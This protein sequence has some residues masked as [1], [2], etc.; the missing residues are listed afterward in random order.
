M[1]RTV[2]LTATKSSS[3]LI[4]GALWNAGPYAL[5]QFALSPP[6][7]RGRQVTAV[8]TPSGSWIDVQ[9]DTVDYDSDNGFNSGV[10]LINYYAQVAGWYWVEGYFAWNN[11][12]FAASRYE[13]SVWKNGSLVAG[14][15]QF[16]YMTA[17]LMSLWGGTMVFL[18]VG[19]SVSFAG[20]QNT[21]STVPTFGGT[22][23]CPCM[24]VFWIHS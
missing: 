5:S 11:G 21:G 12:G 8:F 18:N 22:D 14:A 20:R 15:S 24:N 2:P 1:P 19:D 6:Y 9:V 4:T 13:T 17:D 7:F 23:L 3:Q 10:S 16:S